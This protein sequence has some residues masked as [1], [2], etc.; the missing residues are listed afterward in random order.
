MKSKQGVKLTK[1]ETI[2]NYQDYL[3]I[4]TRVATGESVN[5]ICKE[6]GVMSR[7]WFFKRLFEDDNTDLLDKYR[8]ACEIRSEI[9]AEEIVEVA[10]D[11]SGDIFEDE[12]GKKR[13]NHVRVQRDKL[14]ID[15]MKWQASK[16]NRKRYGDKIDSDVTSNGETVKPL[17]VD[18]DLFKKFYDKS[19]TK[20]KGDSE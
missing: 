19:N 1:G 18:P 13:P 6:D 8:K 5:K 20:A 10:Y 12:E 11:D 17:V 14:K 7:A 2:Y 9:H 3:D 4:I 16:H 15:S